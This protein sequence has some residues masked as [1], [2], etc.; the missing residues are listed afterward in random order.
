MIDGQVVHFSIGGWGMNYYLTPCG[1]NDGNYWVTQ[2]KASVS[3]PKCNE[4]MEP[5]KNK[6]GKKQD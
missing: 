6:G 4:A 1:L 2:N 5:A 3:C